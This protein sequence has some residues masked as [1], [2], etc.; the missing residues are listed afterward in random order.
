MIK[1]S[2]FVKTAIRGLVVGAVV[3]LSTGCA[4][5]ISP[6]GVSAE[7]VEAIRAKLQNQ[8]LATDRF[9]ASEPGRTSIACR[10]AGPVTAPNGKSFETYI[11]EALVSEFKLGGIYKETSNS[12]LKVH[13]T[14]VDFDS[15]IG[16][17][18]WY[19]EGTVTAGGSSF[20]VITDTPFD[21]S[22]VAD[23]ACQEVA[24][25]FPL[26]VQA[27]IKGVISNPALAKKLTAAK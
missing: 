22:F 6:Y 10:G 17:G 5:N 2:E 13:F 20:P 4:Y 27:F 21:A 3:V 24:Q 1:G 9:T 16:A 25:T 26:A 19:I 8:P 14:K 18:H 15:M 7:N 12:K 11:E 23:K